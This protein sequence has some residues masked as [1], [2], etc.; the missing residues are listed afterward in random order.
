MSYKTVVINIKRVDQLPED[1]Y[2]GVCSISVKERNK[3][4]DA[5]VVQ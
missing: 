4:S 1:D 2:L 3:S 5:Y